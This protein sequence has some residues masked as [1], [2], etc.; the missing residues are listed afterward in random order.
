MVSFTYKAKP[1]GSPQ[2]AQ[3]G[4]D[5]RSRVSWKMQA[6]LPQTTY[7]W[8]HTWEDERPIASVYTQST[9]LEAG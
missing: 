1:T 7:V 2:H 4:Q 6:L 8:Y 5:K 9:E 3:V